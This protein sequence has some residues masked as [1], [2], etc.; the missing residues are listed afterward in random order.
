MSETNSS[1][2]CSIPDTAPTRRERSQ[3][4][5]SYDDFISHLKNLPPNPAPPYSDPNS[6][7][8]ANHTPKQPT[9]APNQH[10]P[11][12]IQQSLSYSSFTNSSSIVR[13]DSLA[14]IHQLGYCGPASFGLLFFMMLKNGTVSTDKSL[15]QKPIELLLTCFKYYYQN[16]N[17]TLS[18]LIKQL[19]V[20]HPDTIQCTLAPIFRII[21]LCTLAAKNTDRDHTLSSEILTFDDSFTQAEDLNHL[22]SK[23]IDNSS[24]LKYF[25]LALKK[26][27]K[28]PISNVFEH[29]STYFSIADLFVLSNIFHIN[30]EIVPIITTSRNLR[31]YDQKKEI[32]AVIDR[33]NEFS[34][35]NSSKPKVPMNI[36]YEAF[37]LCE[38]EEGTIDI[39]GHFD[40][41]TEEAKLAYGSYQ[42]KDLDTLKEMA[43]LS[44]TD[45]VTFASKYLAL[46]LPR[47]RPR[48]QRLPSPKRENLPRIDETNEED[49]SDEDISSPILTTSKP[50]PTPPLTFFQAYKQEMTKTPR[51][52]TF[53]GLPFLVS[54]DRQNND[55]THD[56][57]KELSDAAFAYFKR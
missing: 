30:L 7:I 39:N 22:I 54:S 15:Y 51:S 42:Q 40:I 55:E 41:S 13:D 11:P 29:R 6:E 1:I 49:E 21:L 9:R 50:S 4:F 27:N 16:E 32:L 57:F 33:L 37:V 56:P 44:H 43:L 38:P 10:T 25:T 47:V 45:P 20:M 52:E 5:S 19:S 12:S 17:M 36:A 24:N 23:I 53:Q 48:R 31:A 35:L 14:T 2:T 18:A 28:E 8:A 46:L 3:S 26:A 34:R